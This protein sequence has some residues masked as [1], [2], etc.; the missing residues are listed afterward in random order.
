M[1]MM[2]KNE[3][4]ER[5]GIVDE[6]RITVFED[7]FHAV[8]GKMIRVARSHKRARYSNSA[9][10]F[11]FKIITKGGE[12]VSYWEAVQSIKEQTSPVIRIIFFKDNRSK[13]RY[14]EVDYETNIHRDVYLNW[15]KNRESILAE[16]KQKISKHEDQ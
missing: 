13:R 8:Y 15:L 5:N 10:P 7:D 3:T 6:M 2:N 12:A 11:L 14:S 16:I 4:W 1:K 9:C